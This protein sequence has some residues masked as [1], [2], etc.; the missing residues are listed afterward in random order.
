MSGTGT[1]HNG[2]L[3]ADDPAIAGLQVYVVGGAVRDDLLGLPAGDRDWVVVGSTPEAMAQRGFVPVGGDFPVFL[4]PSTKEEYALARTERKTAR[5]YQGFLFYTGADVTLEDDLRRRDLT[6]NAIARDL[7]G[8]LFDPLGGQQD[9]K[10]RILRHVGHAFGE[11]PVRLLRLA[12]FAA[13]FSEFC[14]ADETRSLCQGMVCAG[15]V[16]ALVPE[17][18]WKEVS[19]GLM[20]LTPGRMFG[21]LRACGAL[22]RIAPELA[23]DKTLDGRLDATAKADLPLTSRYALACMHSEQRDELGQ[24]WRVPLVCSDAARLL[25]VV[26]KHA[27]DVMPDNW[28]A[29]MVHVDALRKPDRF[30]DLMRAVALLDPAVAV[31]TWAKRVQAIQSVNAGAI[32]QTCAGD[33]TRIK[34]AVHAARRAAL[35]PLAR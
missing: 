4:H 32:A 29:L 33:P 18:I 34:S 19:R 26:M 15:E 13:R 1:I 25:P 10:R 6:V 14:V 28:L 11:D 7:H 30:L 9:I 23:S 20:T 35:M 21:V 8:Q 17:R 24:R 22:E 31:Q 12:R 5:G 16:D 2:L 27:K 3:G